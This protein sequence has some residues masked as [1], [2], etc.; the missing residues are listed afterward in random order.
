MQHEHFGKCHKSGILHLALK[1]LTKWASEFS[2][3]LPRVQRD[4]ARALALHPKKVS[5]FFSG[6][7]L[8]RPD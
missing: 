4:M 1:R 5:D 8:N 6:L 7:V 2:C 3:L